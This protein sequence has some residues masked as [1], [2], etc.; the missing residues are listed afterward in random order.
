MLHHG[1]R[2]WA[3]GKTLG[4]RDYVGIGAT[5]AK[6]VRAGYWSFV[7]AALHEL[8]RDLL[9]KPMG[10]LLHFRRPRGFGRALP[11]FDGFMGGMRAP[12][13]RDH[14]VFRRGASSPG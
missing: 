6:L 8:S 13:E 1:F 7:P 5:Y 10:D 12:I 14:I 11:W 4:R 3:E 9:L 2:T